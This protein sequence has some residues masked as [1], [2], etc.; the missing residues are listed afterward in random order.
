MLWFFTFFAA[1]YLTI[2]MNRSSN[3]QTYR[4]YF[5]FIS[6]FN[7]QVITSG[8]YASNLLQTLHACI[9]ETYVSVK[10]KLQHPP[11]ATHRALDFFENY[12]SNSSLPGPKC[13]SNSPH[14][15]PYRWSNAPTPGTF[16]RHIN[17]RRTAEAPSVVEQN[18][19][20]YSK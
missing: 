4:L 9:S 2:I 17:D 1:M 6:K 14:Y 16:H 8:N 3:K 5:N 20:K 13:R 10:S 11:R 7:F 15:G 19:Y 18:L 12:C